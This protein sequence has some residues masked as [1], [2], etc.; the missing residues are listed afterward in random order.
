[1]K[2]SDLGVSWPSIRYRI[3]WPWDFQD[4]FGF[5][6][7]QT[8]L[9]GIFALCSLLAVQIAT[10]P[11]LMRSFVPANSCLSAIM[12]LS[13]AIKMCS[14]LAL[15][16]WKN[17][18]TTRSS[19][20]SI[21]RAVKFASI[22]AMI[23][24]VQN[25]AASYSQKNLSVVVYNLLNQSKVLSGALMGYI[26]LGKVQTRSQ[27]VALLLIFIG[28]VVAVT[29]A[30]QNDLIDSSW[31]GVACAL[32]ASA[33]SGLSGSLSDAA[34]QKNYRDSFSFSAELSF[35]VLITMSVG[36]IVDFAVRG[37]E[38]DLYTIYSRGGI[39]SA[40]GI[41]SFSL[42]PMI[43]VLSCSLGGIL[44]G[45]VTKL[46]G[47]VRKGF[48]V[49]VGVVLSALIDRTVLDFSI[50]SALLLALAGVVIHSLESAKMKKL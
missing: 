20:F 25:I 48:A 23:Y 29:G 44:V 49:S 33:L 38:S 17:R 16:A 42:T 30:S 10:Q 27:L 31:S 4:S 40:A 41:S 19:S 14:C 45:Q 2:V 37:Y 36:F 34:I 47:S 7:A 28:A 6:R 3:F 5:M 39:L 32:T 1:M 26:I 18:S 50:I 24:S 15:F 46:V 11:W 43:P 13:E 9:M 12:F 35:F 22:P 21:R 8:S